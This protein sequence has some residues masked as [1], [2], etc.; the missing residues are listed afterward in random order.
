MQSLKQLLK[1][2]AVSLCVVF[3]SFSPFLFVSSAQ[4]Q[5]VVDPGVNSFYALSCPQY[6]PATP[7][8]Y[9]TSCLK[10]SPGWWLSIQD[11]TI[12]GSHISDITN[13][14]LAEYQSH[15]PAGTDYQLITQDAAQTAGNTTYTPTDNN[16]LYPIQTNIVAQ[17]INN[18]TNPPVVVGTVQYYG[19][20]Q[21]NALYANRNTVSGQSYPT[22]DEALCTYSAP[23]V[24]PALMAPAA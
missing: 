13:S 16:I 3:S 18:P 4:A 11:G 1:N 22:M 7:S 20:C 23:C 24:I 17:D 6:N 5:T 8:V 15:A 2:C 14:M 10:A 19:L 9:V 12:Q 21:N